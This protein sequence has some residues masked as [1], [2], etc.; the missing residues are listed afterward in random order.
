MILI[1]LWCWGEPKKKEKKG[2]LVTRVT[3]NIDFHNM[4]GGKKDLSKYMLHR[5]MKVKQVRKYGN[6]LQYGCTNKH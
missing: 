5:K 2:M 6:T 3:S 4:E 1:R